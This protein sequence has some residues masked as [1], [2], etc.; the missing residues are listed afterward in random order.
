MKRAAGVLRIFLSAA[1]LLLCGQITPLAI[2]ALLGQG[3]GLS[4]I[5]RDQA[6]YL[7]GAESSNPRDYDPATEHDSGD[8]LVYSGLVSLDPNLNLVPELAQSWEVAVDGT[9]YIFTLRANARFQD[10]RPV[11]AQDVVYSWERAAD[12]ATAS[13]T[14]LTYLGDIV[15][16]NE[17]HSGKAKHIAGLQVL[18]DHVLKVTLDAPKPYFLYKLTMPVAFV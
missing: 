15:G 11:T 14:V 8:K 1:L 2:P 3:S 9:A 18:T 13:D 6:L 7:L 17:M 5:P 10:G 16:V 12:P 4:A